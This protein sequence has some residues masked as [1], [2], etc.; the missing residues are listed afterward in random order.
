MPQGAASLG[1]TCRAA[2]LARRGSCNCVCRS[3]PAHPR[4]WWKNQARIMS[5]RVPTFLHLPSVPL[6]TLEALVQHSLPQVWKLARGG[7][8]RGGTCN[9]PPRRPGAASGR[10]GGRPHSRPAAPGRRCTRRARQR[11]G[12]ET[13]RAHPPPS[14]A[15]PP[16]AYTTRHLGGGSCRAAARLAGPPGAGRSAQSR[17]SHGSRAAGRGRGRG[18]PA[19]APLPPARSRLAPGHS[20]PPP[21]PRGAARSARR[22]AGGAGRA[23]VDFCFLFCLYSFFLYSFFGVEWRTGERE[24]GRRRRRGRHGAG[25]GAG[26]VGGRGGGGGAVLRRKKGFWGEGGCFSRLIGMVD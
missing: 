8:G 17:Q 5:L 18:M 9:A 13:P 25:G 12:G 21:R 10:P 14:R 26:W 15:A 22:G 24:I 20:G 19:H 1:R 16:S 7:V 6:G 3:Q 11:P 2:S 23:M 4:S